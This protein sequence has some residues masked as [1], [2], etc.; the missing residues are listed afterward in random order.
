MDSLSAYSDEIQQPQHSS[1]R[2]L[3]ETPQQILIS[4]ICEA[5]FLIYNGCSDEARD[6]SFKNI[7]DEFL[8]LIVQVIGWCLHAT[9]DRG[10]N[11]EEEIRNY[12][13]IIKKCVAILL[14]LT[15]TGYARLTISSDD[16]A[17][18]ILSKISSNIM[19]P[20]AIRAQATCVLSNIA[21]D[22]YED[23][24]DNVLKRRAKNFPQFISEINLADESYM[25][26][27]R[28][29]VEAALWNL[30]SF[31]N[32]KVASVKKP[33]RKRKKKKKSNR[34]AN[35]DFEEF[36][37]SLA[38]NIQNKGKNVS[39]SRRRSM[40][41]LRCL[42]YGQ[43]KTIMSSHNALIVALT[44][45][46][47]QDDEKADEKDSKRKSDDSGSELSSF[48]SDQNK[49][50]EEAT[51]CLSYIATAMDTRKNNPETELVLKT[52]AKVTCDKS[53]GLERVM[54][55][56]G[57]RALAKTKKSKLLLARWPGLLDS[58]AEMNLNDYDTDDPLIMAETLSII[59]PVILPS[60]SVF[61][62]ALSSVT[63]VISKEDHKCTKL[64]IMV[65]LKQS[66]KPTNKMPMT[67]NAKLLESLARVAGNH[68]YHISIREKA[69]ETIKNLSSDVRNC[70][71]LAISIILSSLVKVASLTGAAY[72]TPRRISIEALVNLSSLVTN[73]RV[74]AT[75][76][77]LLTCLIR[78]L[79]SNP[80]SNLSASVGNAIKRLTPAL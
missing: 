20:Y 1:L 31:P 49:S 63:K 14:T 3:I 48:K 40:R 28:E 70:E 61:D 58:L 67:N 50:S 46:L 22:Y 34:N 52:L 11:M 24:V 78:F 79:R 12:I 41:L 55:T 9:Y 6:Q 38:Q 44:N 59:T 66:S 77:G 33:D 36:I 43:S 68:K 76:V 65:L 74:M 73:R 21:Y 47:Q 8:H 69:V 18:T 71:A 15:K 32:Q 29:Y 39:S 60:M 37:G 72:N 27:A 35:V 10:M 26:K 42:A 51:E 2:N 56:K 7:G 17:L 13:N 16:D 30:N 54:A 5:L 80:N 62:N 64:M 45:F 4:Q 23:N 19:I 75:Q 25:G 57:L 53:K